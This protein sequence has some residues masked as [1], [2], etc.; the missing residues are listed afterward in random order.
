MFCMTQHKLY[1]LY[2]RISTPF[3]YLS[4]WLWFAVADVAVYR[5]LVVVVITLNRGCLRRRGWNRGP[6]G[7]GRIVLTR[8]VVVGW[9]HAHGDSGGRWNGGRVGW[10]YQWRWRRV[11]VPFVGPTLV[12]RHHTAVIRR[13]FRHQGSPVGAQG[14][15]VTSGSGVQPAVLKFL[16]GKSSNTCLSVV[17]H[18]RWLMWTGVTKWGWSGRMWVIVWHG[19]TSSWD[20]SASSFHNFSS[21]G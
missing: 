5:W 14:S 9:G 7:W 11:S 21:T 3:S 18:G 20:T 2:V 15:R 17:K 1:L 19:W 10:R 4:C 13:C 12:G 6:R 8:A 16:Q